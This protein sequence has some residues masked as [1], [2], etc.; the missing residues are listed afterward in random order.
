MKYKT[1][2]LYLLEPTQLENM[3]YR[4]A[5]YMKVSGARMAMKHYKNKAD[6]IR[7]KNSDEYKIWKDKYIASEKAMKFNQELIEEMNQYKEI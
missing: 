2:D 1:E 4:E 5:L 6:Q 3:P 7:N